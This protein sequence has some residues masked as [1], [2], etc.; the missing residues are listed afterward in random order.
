MVANIGTSFLYGFLNYENG[1]SQKIANIIKGDTQKS[2][3][4]ASEKITNSTNSLSQE[5]YDDIIKIGEDLALSSFISADG[6]LDK[7][8]WECS[9]LHVGTLDDYI[10]TRQNFTNTEGMIPSDYEAEFNDYIKSRGCNN[11]E[12]LQILCSAG[13]YYTKNDLT[14]FAKQSILSMSGWLKEG[15][16]IAITREQI[17]SIIS[18]SNLQNIANYINSFDKA[19]N[20]ADQASSFKT[21][22]NNVSQ[23]DNINPDLGKILLNLSQSITSLSDAIV[24]YSDEVEESAGHTI[25]NNIQKYQASLIEKYQS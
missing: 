3:N 24:K 4:D 1:N 2:Y 7:F 19:G 20:F 11:Q 17:S 22:I 8:Y 21:F 18:N 10:S 12:E 15:V 25:S 6:K 16:G 9:N 14:W 13:C 23:Q 5:S